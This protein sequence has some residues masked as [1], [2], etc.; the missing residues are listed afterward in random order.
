[1]HSNE[2]VARFRKSANYL[3]R[4]L[5]F[6]PSLRADAAQEGWI[7][8]WQAWETWPDKSLSYYERAIRNR[9]ID[10]LNGASL[11]VN[12]TNNGGRGMLQVTFVA[13]GLPD[14]ALQAYRTVEPKQADEY[15]SDQDWAYQ[16]CET[17]LD[18][19]LVHGVSSGLQIKEV[20]ERA[21]LPVR[22]VQRYWQRH[23]K[24]RLREAWKG[25][26]I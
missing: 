20:A 22:N 21:G 26:N 12:R 5:V 24:P 4:T 17:S 1:M 6:D 13:T 7:R 15:P 9:I 23:T 8:A 18:L 2:T 3:A 14:W 16:A 10:V 19:M 25:V 11:G